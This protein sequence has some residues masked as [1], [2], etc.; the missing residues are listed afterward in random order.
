MHG[1]FSRAD[2]WNFMAMAGPDFRSHFVDPAPTSTAD[3]GRTIAQL[4]QLDPTDNG[5]LIGRVLTEALPGG[6]LPEVSSRVVTSEAAAN[7]VTTVINMQVVGNIRYFD[8]GG[9][10]GRTVGLTG[11]ARLSATQ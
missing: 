7:G 1:S 2:T 11:T 8:A 4:L 10:P 3:L 6:A 9:F 5:T